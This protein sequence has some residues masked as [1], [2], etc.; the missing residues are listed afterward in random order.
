[1]SE[2]QIHT[3]ARFPFA[4]HIRLCFSEQGGLPKE[5]EEEK[6]KEERKRGEANRQ[7]GREERKVGAGWPFAA[8][9]RT[10]M[11]KR[12]DSR[13]VCLASLTVSFQEAQVPSVRNYTSKRFCSLNGTHK[14]WVACA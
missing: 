10:L 12:K 3:G 9:L 8:F 13:P 1:M 5:E 6:E 11:Y 2:K 4:V 7:T 14:T